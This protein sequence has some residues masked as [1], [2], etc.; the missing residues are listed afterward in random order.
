MCRGDCAKLHITTTGGQE[1]VYQGS[2]KRIKQKDVTKVRL[3]GTGCFRIHKGRGFTG[4]E[5][6]VEGPNMLD[7]KGNEVEWTVVK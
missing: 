4:E 1:K 3:V 7:L 5:F 6:L 2:H